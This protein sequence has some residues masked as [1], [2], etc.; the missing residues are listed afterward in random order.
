MFPSLREI[1]YAREII[2][3][4]LSKTKFKKIIFFFDQ[5]SRPLKNLSGGFL[6][7]SQ[8]GNLINDIHCYHYIVRGFISTTYFSSCLLIDGALFDSLYP[9]KVQICRQSQRDLLK[10]EPKPISKRRQKRCVKINTISHH[11]SFVDYSH[12]IY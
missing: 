8:V 9:R 6:F 2:D 11:R 12:L 4:P 1:T 10:R 5:S 7:L 3:G